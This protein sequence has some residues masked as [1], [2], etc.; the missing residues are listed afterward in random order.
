MYIYIYVYIYI[1]I[2]VY[3]Y[4]YILLYTHSTYLGGHSTTGPPFQ[5]RLT[6]EFLG[7]KVLSEME[8]DW[9][10]PVS[11]CGDGW[12][13]HYGGLLQSARPAGFEGI[14]TK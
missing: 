13:G 7:Q 4:I 3:T 5:T 8:Q 11:P 2:C 12:F 14:E 6:Y 1:Y 10:A 9:S